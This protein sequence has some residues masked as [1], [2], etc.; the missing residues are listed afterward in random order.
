MSTL[1]CRSRLTIVNSG[2]LEATY[3][4]QKA[5]AG[6]VFG[7]HGGATR[8][9]VKSSPRGRSKL[10]KTLGFLVSGDYDA[11]IFMNVIYNSCDP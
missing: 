1:V 9:T 2:A 8:P 11:N 5:V 3:K 7:K 4:L 10:T 6:I